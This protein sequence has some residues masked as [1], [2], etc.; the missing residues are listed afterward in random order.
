MTDSNMLEV[1]LARV[2]IRD[3]A[4]RQYIFLAESG[5]SRAFPI[6]IGNSEACEI[7]RILH[8]IET[9]RPLTHQL[10]H[11]AITGL[12]ATLKRVDIVDL[13]HNT[14]YAQVVL[15]NEAGDEVAVMDARPSDAIA[16]ALRAKC[17]IHVAE[18]VIERASADMADPDAPD[19]Q[20][21]PDAPDAP[22]ESGP[23]L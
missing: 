1:A 3:D 5:S 21:E 14:F 12:G 23:A 8:G 6:V 11:S 4:D 18:S 19:A 22:E 10:L 9:E 20:D 13:K 16:L 15:Q 7:H 2:V 17:A